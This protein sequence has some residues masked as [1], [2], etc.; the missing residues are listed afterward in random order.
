MTKEEAR[1]RYA[2][3]VRDWRSKGLCN[4]NQKNTFRY[5]EGVADWYKKYPDIKIIRSKAFP[6]AFPKKRKS[7]WKAL[8]NA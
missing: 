8:N 5:G 6:K 3:S 2:A 7:I 4:T 1:K